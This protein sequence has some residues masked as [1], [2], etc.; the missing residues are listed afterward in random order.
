MPSG[1]IHD[2]NEIPHQ[3][4]VENP[5]VK[6]ATDPRRKQG[7]GNLDDFAVPPGKQDHRK[8][9]DKR[10]HRDRYKKETLPGGNSKRRAGISGQVQT[11]KALNYCET[12]P[13]AALKPSENSAF[14]P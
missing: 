1:P 9:H 12:V 11:Q 5:V 14:T 3:A 4:V 7:K 13:S 6:I 10:R 8:H 2:V